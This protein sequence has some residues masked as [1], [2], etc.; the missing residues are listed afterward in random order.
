MCADDV[1]RGDSVLI[2]AGSSKTFTR[3]VEVELKGPAPA[4]G[5]STFATRSAATGTA[6]SPRQTD[7]ASGRALLLDACVR[8]R[9][10]GLARLLLKPGPAAPA[11]RELG[12]LSHSRSWRR[13]YA[14][15]PCALRA[16]AGL[17]H[18]ADARTEWKQPD[19]NARVRCHAT[20]APAAQ[21]GPA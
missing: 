18:C 6:S 12:L 4:P 11:R 3:C 16:G 19:S 17:A 8:P 9:K 7:L 1:S 5:C 2:S 14:A 13:R 10:A 20:A 15:L 21:A